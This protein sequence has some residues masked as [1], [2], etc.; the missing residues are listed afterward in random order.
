MPHR[1]EQSEPVVF[2]SGQS[3]KFRVDCTMR[4]SEDHVNVLK[5]S[6]TKGL[7]HGAFFHQFQ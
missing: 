6:L 3:A 4:S 5:N 2:F 7:K 1:Q